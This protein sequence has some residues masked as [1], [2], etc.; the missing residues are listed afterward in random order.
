MKALI[1]IAYIAISVLIG[2]ALIQV[3]YEIIKIPRTGRR[4][5]KL[6]N[7]YKTVQKKK[8]SIEEILIRPVAKILSKV[9]ILNEH[10]TQSLMVKLKEAGL[11][12]TPKEYYARAIIISVLP[13]LILPVA[14]KAEMPIVAI[15][16]IV[17]SVVMYFN[18]VDINTIIK[19]RQQEIRSELPRFI[20]AIISGLNTNRDLIQTIEKYQTVSKGVLKEEIGILLAAL[21]SGNAERAYMTFSQRL[22]MPEIQRLVTALINIER[23][24]DQA[25]TLQFLAADTAQMIQDAIKIEMAKRPRI[26]RRAMIPALLTVF[27]MLLYVVIANFSDYITILY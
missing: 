5:K 21:Q 16:L 8:N 27:V 7:K 3:M 18:A 10:R 11:E 9:I 15:A 4:K 26:L 24:V 6:L 2:I 20:R 14:F 12:Y 13:L 17:L 23:G 22:G 25:T 19:K 1:Y